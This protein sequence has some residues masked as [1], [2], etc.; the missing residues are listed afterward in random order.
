MDKSLDFWKVFKVNL[1]ILL[2]IVSN[3]SL[4]G[5][6]PVFTQY[7]NAQLYLNPAFAGNTIGPHVQAGYR[8]QW[9]LLPTLYT[10]FQISY[11]QSVKERAGLGLS[12]LNDN[13]GLGTLQNTGASG[14]YSY[15]IRIKNDIYIKGGINVGINYLSFNADKL[16]FGDGIDPNNGPLSA[17]GTPLPTAENIVSTAEKY[18]SI[19][20]GFLLYNPRYYIGLSAHNLN[21]PE[22]FQ[23]STSGLGNFGSMIPIRWNFHA[24]YQHNFV[25]GNK[26]SF[27]SFLSPSVLYIDQGRFKQLNIGA[28]LSVNS[29]Q[30]GGFYRHTFKNSDAVIGL[31][32]F[33]KHF[34]KITYSFDY[35][36]SDLS[37]S[38]GGSHE[39]G[40][41]FNFDYLYPKKTNYNDCFQIFR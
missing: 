21:S 34:L 17:G 37:I 3:L 5:Q 29:F 6:D 27:P 38:Q 18:L 36:V 9:P 25:E 32:G 4:F 2:F 23:V 11:D 40:L 1:W 33:Q 16:I 8:H 30:I 14:Y 7:F 31:V 26:T 35:T 20:S 13:A 22:I 12:V 10:T 15:K 39:L 24:G 41:N 28:I 19:G